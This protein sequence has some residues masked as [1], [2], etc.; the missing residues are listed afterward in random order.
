MLQDQ[1][2]RDAPQNRPARWTLGAIGLRVLVLCLTCAAWSPAHAYTPRTFAGCTPITWATQP[3]VVLHISEFAG[4]D[5]LQNII[6]LLQITNA[7]QQVHGRFN[8]MGGTGAW[9]SGFETS[10]DPFVFKSWFGDATPTIHVGFTNDTSAA[11]G[12]TYWDVDANCNIVEAHIQFR[13]PYVYGWTF[14]DPAAHDEPYYDAGLFNPDGDVYFRISYVHELLHAFGLAHPADAYS[15]LNYGDRPWANRDSASRIQPL[16]DDVE[17]MRALYPLIGA[18]ADIA[19]L[20]TWFEPPANPVGTYPAAVQQRLCKPSL[21]N[22]WNADRYATVCGLTNGVAGSTVI[23]AGQTLRTRFAVANYST[24]AAD[25]EARIYF[26]SDDT[27][28]ALDVAS[29]T[30]HSFTVSESGSSQQGRTWTVP[31]L[32]PGTYYVIARVEATLPWG[33]VLADWIP[34][35]GTVTVN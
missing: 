27:W 14:S 23:A 18:R 28:D 24:D 30:T 21:G 33:P 8:L 25:V 22:A 12:G 7:I 32:P 2:R 11:V 34:L 1:V 4:P 13:D 3:R 9:V 31:A 19:V 10:T 26:S 29:A 5:F 35:R 15:M 16:P 17:G 6:N 20:N